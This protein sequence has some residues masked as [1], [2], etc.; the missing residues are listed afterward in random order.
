[1]SSSGLQIFN[2]SKKDIGTQM[3]RHDRFRHAR[4]DESGEAISSANASDLYRRGPGQP[5]RCF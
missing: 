2:S 4:N 5:Q 3:F 1:M